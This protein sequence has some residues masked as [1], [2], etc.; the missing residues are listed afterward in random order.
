MPAPSPSSPP[1]PG[2]KC[3]KHSH[4]LFPMMEPWPGVPETSEPGEQ[5][6][7]TTPWGTKGVRG[8]VAGWRGWGVAG[9][10]G[11][12]GGREAEWRD[13]GVGGT[14]G[15]GE[16]GWQGG[17]PMLGRRGQEG[18]GKD[19]IEASSLFTHHQARNS[20]N[21]LE[22]SQDFVFLK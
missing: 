10:R 21:L 2:L 12:R 9:W 19:S 8:G 13:G 14:R 17:E 15:G 4:R 7:L 22:S 11:W 1:P 18:R 20:L 5:A 3:H 16:V 6:D